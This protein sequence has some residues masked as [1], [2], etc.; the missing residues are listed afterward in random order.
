[1]AEVIIAKQRHGPV[2]TVQL[3]FD[4]EVTKFDN[5]ARTTT[6]PDTVAFYTRRMTAPEHAGAFSPPSTSARSPRTGDCCA[7]RLGGAECG[8]M[9]KADAYGLGL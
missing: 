9:V 4:G 2:G 5:L 1:M 8:A 7:I 3:F 6:W